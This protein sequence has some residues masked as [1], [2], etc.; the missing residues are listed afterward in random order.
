MN[1]IDNDKHNSPYNYKEQRQQDTTR[2]IIIKQRQ[3]HTTRHIT[4]KHNDNNTQL[5]I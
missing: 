3:Q 2:N 4:I 5:V 1:H